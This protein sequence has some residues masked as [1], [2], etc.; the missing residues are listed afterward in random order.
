MKIVVYPAALLFVLSSTGCF[1]RKDGNQPMF[2]PATVSPTA[3]SPAANSPATNAPSTN[4]IFTV[5][6]EEGLIGR[7]ATVNANLGFAVL[8]FP[9][10]QMPPVDDRLNV[11][12]NGTKVGELKV[13]GPQ[14]E[15][16]T[17]A[18]IVSGDAEKGDEVREH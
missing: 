10:G 13:T 6:P 5:T 15:D 7:V 4:E 2:P 1:W 16:N 12:R 18:D 9:V 11:Y 17:V 14:R 3:V 8:T